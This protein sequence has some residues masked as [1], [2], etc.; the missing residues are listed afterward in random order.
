MQGRRTSGTENHRCPLLDLSYHYAIEPVLLWDSTSISATCQFVIFMTPWTARLPRNICM[1]IKYIDSGWMNGVA[2]HHSK[3][4]MRLHIRNQQAW[5]SDVTESTFPYK[6]FLLCSF[7]RLTKTFA[8]H[9][10]DRRREEDHRETVRVC[11]Q[12]CREAR[13]VKPT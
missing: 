4:D 3:D 6:F 11:G 5:A 10:A 7:V 9:L 8:T 1:E 13:L 2:Y 12:L